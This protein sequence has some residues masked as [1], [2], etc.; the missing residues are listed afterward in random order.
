MAGLGPEGPGSLQPRR[1]LSSLE[2]GEDRGVCWGTECVGGRA[3]QMPWGSSLP[4]R[5]NSRWAD[6][7]GACSSPHRHD[8]HSG[9]E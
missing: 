2:H 6:G 7:A 5:H 9:V 8:G 4:E 1:P 3:S